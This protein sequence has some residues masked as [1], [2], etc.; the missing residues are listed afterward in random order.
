MEL[1]GMPLYTALMSLLN[2]AEGRR[3]NMS[4][5]EKANIYSGIDLSA[6]SAEL[7]QH[8]VHSIDRVSDDHVHE[9]ENANDKMKAK[10]LQVTTMLQESKEDAADARR[11]RPCLSASL[12]PP[13]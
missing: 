10:L 12:P 2:N 6:L 3:Q 11:S 1:T 5:L 8:M 13:H 7:R 4:T 9:L